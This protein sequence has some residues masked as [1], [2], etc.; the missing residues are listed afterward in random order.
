[1]ILMEDW[2]RQVVTCISGYRLAWIL[3]LRRPEIMRSAWPKSA[4]SAP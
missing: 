3:G 1:M 4:L 2:P